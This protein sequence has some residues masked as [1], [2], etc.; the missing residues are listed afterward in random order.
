MSKSSAAD[1]LYVVERVNWSF[2]FQMYDPLFRQSRGSQISTI[3][4][5]DRDDRPVNS[6]DVYMS[7]YAA[8]DT[9]ADV[10]TK[11][12]LYQV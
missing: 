3:Y 11:C 4:L 2:L 1:V 10:S 8:I 7:S 5:P 6:T 9:T 12:E